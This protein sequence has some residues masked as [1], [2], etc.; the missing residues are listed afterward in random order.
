MKIKPNNARAKAKEIPSQPGCYLFKDI[1]GN[2]LYVGKSKC[3]SKRVSSYWRHEIKYKNK[4]PVY[5][6]IMY[7]I[8]GGIKD[9]KLQ[10]MMQFVADVDYFTTDTDIEAILL[11]HRLIKKYR[12]PY[13]TKMR[14][15]KERWY[16]VIDKSRI[17]PILFVTCELLKTPALFYIGP[18]SRKE[19][20]NDTLK[21]IGDYWQTAVCG[22]MGD[23]RKSPCLRFHIK[24]C[25]GPCRYDFE[26]SDFKTDLKTYQSA[27]ESALKFLS[28]DTEDVLLGISEEIQKASQSLNFEKA[29]FLHNQY[30]ELRYVA[31]YLSH[32]PPDLEGDFC[33]FMKSRHEKCFLLIHIQNRLVKSWMRFSSIEGWED[34]AKKMMHYIKTGDVP[35]IPSPEDFQVFSQDDSLRICKAVLDVEAI[36]Y[37]IDITDKKQDFEHT[38]KRIRLLIN[39]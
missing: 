18:F 12:P 33:V 13:N 10:M 15:D 6:A 32:I 17:C 1:D 30:N 34:K 14:K 2:I 28:G 26:Q 31:N 37:F 19:Y 20:A 25:I 8:N 3:L 21:T 24:Q 4:D 7:Q 16:I 27:V 23:A 11:E 22:F 5:S 36:K 29:A 35:I 39:F 38:V 9:E